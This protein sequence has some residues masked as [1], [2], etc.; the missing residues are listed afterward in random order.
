[1]AETKKAAPKKAKPAAKTAAA[2]SAKT[3]TT[4]TTKKFQDYTIKTKRSGRFLV[5]GKNGKTVN[6]AD[7]TKVLIAAKLVKESLPKAKEEAAPTA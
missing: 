5:L 3:T 6:G 1:M 7:K 4:S 2:A